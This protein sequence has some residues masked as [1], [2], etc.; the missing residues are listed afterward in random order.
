MPNLTCSVH[1]C[2]STYVCMF[3]RPLRAFFARKVFPMVLA[4]SVGCHQ[5]PPFSA[6]RSSWN[7]SACA[8]IVC[9]VASCRLR[10]RP[11]LCFQTPGP[12][13]TRRSQPE[14]H[15]AEHKRRK[16]YQDAD[17][18]VMQSPA[19]RTAAARIAAAMQHLCGCPAWLPAHTAPRSAL[20][21]SPQTVRPPARHTLHFHL[22]D[23]GRICCNP[24]VVVPQDA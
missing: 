7:A 13:H 10:Y 18:R 24:S 3:S 9:N 17:P 15:R 11:V 23:C 4:R 2:A 21:Q 19:K 1:G 20:R 12:D 16:R 5:S 22:R 6:L 8:G 14:S